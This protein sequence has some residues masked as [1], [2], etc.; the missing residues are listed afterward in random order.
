MIS[1]ITHI[2]L[3]VHSIDDALAFYTIK[4]G[5]KVHTDV[6]LGDFRWVTICPESQPDFEIALMLA[7]ND[8]EKALVG[9]QAAS[10]P[11]IC[12]ETADCKKDY[13]SLKAAGVI[14]TQKPQQEPWGISANF[15]DLYGTVLYMCQ[16]NRIS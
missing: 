1:K 2:S 9:K 6:L 3:L 7:K 8:E 10:Y 14:F 16:T 4:L 15:K 11:F 5:F 13:E 12:F